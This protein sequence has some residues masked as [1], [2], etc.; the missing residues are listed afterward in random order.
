MFANEQLHPYRSSDIYLRHAYTMFIFQDKNGWIEISSNIHTGF[1]ALCR[2]L[3]F[4]PHRNKN[5]LPSAKSTAG[6]QRRHLSR[7]T[8]SLFPSF[9]HLTKQRKVKRDIQETE[10]WDDMHLRLWDKLELPTLQKL[11][12]LTSTLTQVGQRASVYSILYV[13]NNN[14]A[15]QCAIYSKILKIR[16]GALAHH[17]VSVP[18]KVKTHSAVNSNASFITI[19]WE[20]VEHC[21]VTKA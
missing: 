1:D 10:M 2:N 13:I 7:L 17:L 3:L 20:T 11:S 15:L 14:W 8:Y 12:S 16:F 21:G 19:K 6:P 18:Y 5:S 9:F 4:S